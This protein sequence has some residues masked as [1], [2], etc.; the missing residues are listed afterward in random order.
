[1]TEKKLAVVAGAARGIGRA[2]C[3]KLLKQGFE[4]ADKFVRLGEHIK[5]VGEHS[6]TVRFAVDLTAAVKVIV[7]SQVG[8]AEVANERADK[9]NED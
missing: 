8:N 2:I 6:V 3:L 1:M 9:N 7:V 5:E 4:V